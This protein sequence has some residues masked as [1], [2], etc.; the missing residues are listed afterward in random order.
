MAEFKTTKTALNLMRAYAGES[1]ARNRYT[2]YASVAKKQGFIQISNIF[3]ETADNEKEHAK[4][5]YKKLLENN[6]LGENVE[7]IET[8]Y[9]VALTEDTIKNLEFAANGELEEWSKVYPQ[10]ARDAETEGY[11]DISTLF[12]MIAN[13][14]EAHE[15]RYKKLLENMKDKTVFKKDGKVFWKCIN[16]GFLF[17]NIEAPEHCP[18]CHHPKAY[19]ELFVENY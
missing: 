7:L 18:A 17:E 10:F 15:K 9:P 13:A 19:F 14:E 3:M 16:C 5:F 6:M 1:Q 12:K 4:L 11:K 2:Y 8:S